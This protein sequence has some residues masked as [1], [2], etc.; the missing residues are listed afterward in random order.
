MEEKNEK[1]SDAAVQNALDPWIS[2][3]KTEPGI[4]SIESRF[5]NS[6]Q[7]N[8]EF[9]LVKHRPVHFL[10]MN[11]LRHW[12]ISVNGRDWHPGTHEVSDIFIKSSDEYSI[13]VEVKELCKFCTYL[14]FIE[15]FEHDKYFNIFTSNCELIVGYYW[16]T[17]SLFLA[18][19]CLFLFLITHSFLFLIVCFS[20]LFSL[21]FL[22]I[23]KKN[24]TIT[25]CKH[26][27]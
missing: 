12:F 3:H 5:D 1:Y 6:D 2:F 24:V 11:F 27:K 10:N 23:R 17:T 26:V 22:L 18:T 20:L 15:L 13:L 9:L 14:Y 19:C 4:H 8:T 7:Q 16:E 21:T 25:K